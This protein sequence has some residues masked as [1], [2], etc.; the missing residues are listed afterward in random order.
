MIMTM[1]TNLTLPKTSQC[2]VIYTRGG[3]A[4]SCLM[5]TPPTMDA[6][7]VKMLAKQIGISS[8]VRVEPVQNYAQDRLHHVSNATATRYLTLQA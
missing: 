1:K 4:Y 2:N 7:Q 8:V 5:P 3:V 6:L